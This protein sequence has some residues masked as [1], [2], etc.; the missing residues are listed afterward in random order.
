MISVSTAIRS[1]Q[2]C[3]EHPKSGLKA[4]AGVFLAP[5][6]AANGL[7]LPAPCCRHLHSENPNHCPN[8]IWVKTRK[9]RGYLKYDF[10]SHGAPHKTDSELFWQT[11]QE[12]VEKYNARFVNFGGNAPESPAAYQEEFSANLKAVIDVLH[13]DQALVD[14]LADTL[15]ELGESVP[16]T[17]GSFELGTKGNPFTDKRLFDFRNYPADLYAKPGDKVPNR[18][19]LSKWGAWVN[20]FGAKEYGRPLFLVASADLAESTNL[21]GFG[22]AYGDFTGYGWY[23]RF[24]ESEGVILPQEITEFANAGIMSGLATVNLSSDPEKEFDGFWG[25]CSTYGSF[26]YLNMACSAC[27]ASLARTAS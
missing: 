7:P 20:A 2:L 4:M 23:R 13:A 10:A 1:V 18:A 5:K 9:G 6:M 3:T 21:S 26:S 14:Y 27:L 11:K 12:F 16:E 22:A 19:G 17:L 24:G 15:V 8:G 25:A